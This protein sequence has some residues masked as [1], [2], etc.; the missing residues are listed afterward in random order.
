MRNAVTPERLQ[1]LQEKM[2]FN[3]FVEAVDVEAPCVFPASP[4]ADN[5]T[6]QIIYVDG[7]LTAAG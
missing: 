3:C 5:I 4:E 2:L 6:G 1:S 7:G